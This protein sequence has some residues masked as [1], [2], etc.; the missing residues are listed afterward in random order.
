MMTKSL[1]YEIK[2]Q[3][4]A[5]CHNYDFV[6]YLVISVTIISTNILITDY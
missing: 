5:F 3:S 1:N 6:T 4:R 2:R